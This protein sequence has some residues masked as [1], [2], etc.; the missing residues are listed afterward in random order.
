MAARRSRSGADQFAEAMEGLLVHVPAWVGPLIAVAV[1]VAFR[2]VL[3]PIVAQGGETFE[4]E[5]A[6]L[7]RGLAL[8]VT[9]VLAV[10][11]ILGEIKKR[12]RRRLLDSRSDVASLRSL[13]WLEF[14]QLV[15]EAYR[16][17]GY[18]VEE[19]GGGGT[20]GG[21]DLILYG[22][23]T[24]TL[25]QCKQW[26]TWKVGV[27]VVRELYGVVSAERAAAGIVV[28]C[29]QFTREAMDFAAGKPL[30]LVNGP[31]LWSLVAAVK[32]GSPSAGQPIAAAAVNRAGPTPSPAPAQTS[33]Q[34]KSDPPTCPLCGSSMVLRTARRGPNAGS[35]FYGCSKYPQCCGIRPVA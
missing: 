26:K 34:L 10:I 4:R 2:F 30:E 8:P 12:S 3:P 19:T 15:G 23:G 11:W 35:Q 1:F 32:A 6:P 28:T 13:N 18:R 5:F 14:E 22:N 27:K 7:C 29:G 33:A 31:G 21:V 16:R 20:D 24:K 17:R 25:V 9:A